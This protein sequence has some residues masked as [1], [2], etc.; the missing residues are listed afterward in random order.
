MA[1]VL[2]WGWEPT[3]KKWV[4]LRVDAD[5]SI[6]VVGYVDK[7]DDI[8]DVDVAAPGDGNFLYWDAAGPK[9]KDKAMVGG[10]TEGA[11]VYNSANISIPDATWTALT[12]DTERWDTDAIHDLITNPD[13]LTCKTAGK[14]LVAVCV[15]FNTNAVGL[16]QLI[17]NQYTPGGAS[18]FGQYLAANPVGTT[19]FGCSCIVDMAVNDWLVTQVYQTSGAALDISHHADFSPEFM[20]ARIG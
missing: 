12:F 16:R 14:Y 13:R 11:R 3:T 2:M 9:W 20:V 4:K 7:L 8:G 5:G 1:G 15:E 19:V 17:I 10:Y 6:H 18:I